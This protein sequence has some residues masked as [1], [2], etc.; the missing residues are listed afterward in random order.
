MRPSSHAP[1]RTG[2]TLLTTG[3]AVLATA[4]V[5][6][7]A[8][9]ATSWGIADQKPATFANPAFGELRQA[10]MTMARYTMR[11]D[12]TGYANSRSLGYHAALADQ[13]LAAA[14][15]ANVRPLIT[16]WVTASS[17]K[18]LK[19]KISATRFRTEFRRFR[20]RHPEVRDFSLFN[21]PN[22]TG[23]YKRDPAALGRLY[24]TISKELKGCRSCRL[25]VGDLHLTSGRA[26][27]DYALKVRRAAKMPIRIW[28]L[29]NYN[30]VNDRTST[31][32]GRFL[33]STAVRNS[34]VW[35]TES[36]GVYSRKLSS[37]QKNPFL[38]QRR[39]AKSDSAR[40]KY[41]YDATRYLNT[42]AKRYKRQIQRVYT[43][44]LQSEPNATW[45]RGT[46]NHSWDSGLLD[47]RGEKRRSF[48]YV[49]KH[50]L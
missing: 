3:A 45:V 38:A 49:L 36:G 24:R 13:W 6:A 34:K 9:A 35:I 37:E 19:R 30:D 25:L 44:Q 2:R 39:K 26:A 7:P 43:Y 17:S 8:D 23:P 48:D 47:P 21:E 22:L 27:G 42:I 16:F 40:E 11:Y 33:R 41:Q 32:T 46:R 14:K 50:V 31:Q 28:G 18:S 4:A 15:A 29:N 12:A 20:K 1:R 5:A 10:G